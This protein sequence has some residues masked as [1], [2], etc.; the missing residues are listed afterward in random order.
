M[1]EKSRYDPAAVMSGVAWD[2]FCD[3]LKEAGRSVTHDKAPGSPIDRA[4]GFR[5][6]LEL[7][8]LAID[9]VVERP[10]P[11]FPSFFPVMSP[12][13]K[14]GIDNPD[15]NYESTLIKGD[16]SY[17]IAG[18]RGTVHYV[19]LTVYAGSTGGQG[20][21]R[22]VAH[23]SDPE[24]RVADDGRFE[25][26]LSP[27]PEPDGYEGNW[28]VIDETATSVTIRQYFLDRQA[29]QPATYTIERIGAP[30]APPPLSP[31]VMARALK[32]TAWQ[33]NNQIAIWA[34]VAG[35]LRRHPN[36]FSVQP[37]EGSGLVMATPDNIYLTGY[38]KLEPDEALVVDTVPPDARY[39]N[40]HLC[41]FWNQSLDY[42][43]HQVNINAAGAVRNDDGGVTFVIAGSDP[44]V[45]NWLDTAGHSEGVM[46][47]RWML[48]S[49]S[50]HPT[51]KVMKLS[52]V[53]GLHG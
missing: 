39:W 48:S 42:R 21:A 29:E 46:T 17:R 33:V 37:G 25:V 10:D 50:P 41:N 22:Y 23:L 27:D 32:K 52:E 34:R 24:L 43:Y 28:V 31:A 45:P 44:G 36:E 1:A 8:S 51:C 35:A 4:E 3:T 49:T 47:F 19:G 40:F 15:A 2:E 30:A 11:D 12:T 9:S 18:R 6:L 5:Y 7:L 20:G 38:F 26:T 14:F 16:R 13:R 53:R